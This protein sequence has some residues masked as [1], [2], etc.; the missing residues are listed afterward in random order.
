MKEKLLRPALV[1]VSE[2]KKAGGAHRGKR[3]RPPVTLV[4]ET[5]LP[6]T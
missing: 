4:I 1:P 6:Y 5:A 3:T 2:D